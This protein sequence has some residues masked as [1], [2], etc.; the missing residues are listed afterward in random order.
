MDVVKFAR[1]IIE[2]DERV[3]ELEWENAELRRY[4]DDYNRLLNES[5]SHNRVIVG[6]LLS[7]GL[8]MAE[9]K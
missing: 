1:A 3:Q 8:K 4:R 7:V 9:D 2:L 6:G 5:V